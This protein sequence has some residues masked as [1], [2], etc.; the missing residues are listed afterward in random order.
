MLWTW[1]TVSRSR[2]DAF[3]KFCNLFHVELDTGHI[4]CKAFL[5]DMLQV[6]TAITYTVLC[7]FQGRQ[8][9][10]LYDEAQQAMAQDDFDTARQKLRQ[11]HQIDPQVKP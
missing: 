11:A 5:N 8:A 3:S 6:L 2:H 4:I 10:A 9:V 7:V 1:S